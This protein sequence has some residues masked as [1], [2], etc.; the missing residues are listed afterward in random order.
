MSNHQHRHTMR[1]LR[2]GRVTISASVPRWI[3][4]P[5]TYQDGIESDLVDLPQLRADP[6]VRRDI[7]V[8][9]EGCLCATSSVRP[10]DLRARDGRV[11]A[12]LLADPRGVPGNIGP[13]R[14]LHGWRGT[15]DDECVTSHGWRRVEAIV[16]RRH[17]RA[18]RVMLSPDIRPA[19]AEA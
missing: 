16:R 14:R 7:Q 12:R 9:D 4:R 5:T 11:T 10:D 18:W 19:E 6:S 17:G 2:D 1:Y 8:G 13:Q 15:T 3:A